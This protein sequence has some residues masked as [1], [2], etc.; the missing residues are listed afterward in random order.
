[1]L[2][3]QILALLHM[4]KDKQSHTKIINLKYQLH[5]GMKSFDY[6]MD[7]NLY[8]VLKT[9]LGISSENMGQ[10]TDNPSMMIYVNDIENRITFKIK[11]GYYF[12]LLTPETMKL[13]RS[14]KSKVT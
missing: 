3:Y 13:L 7:H 9:I 11:A 10:V 2:L 6:L 8:Q 14:T 1:M 5:H 12:E 4:E